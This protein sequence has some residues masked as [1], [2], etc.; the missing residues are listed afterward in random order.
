MVNG[1]AIGPEINTNGLSPDDISDLS[2]YNSALFGGII[3]QNGGLTTVRNSYNTGNITTFSSMSAGIM[4]NDWGATSYIINCYNTGDITASGNVGGLIGLGGYSI[5]NSYNTGV[6]TLFASSEG[7]NI[8]GLVG[9]RSRNAAVVSNSYNEGNI[10]VTSKVSKIYAAGLCGYC[11]SIDNS[12]NRGNITSKY[13]SSTLA[14]IYASSIGTGVTNVYN[15]GNITYENLAG[16]PGNQY[17]YAQASGI[18]TFS[19]SAARENAYNLGN[20]TIEVNSDFFKEIMVAGVNLTSNQPVNNCVNTGNITVNVN[21]PRTQTTSIFVSGISYMENVYNSFN[22][23]TLTIND[24]AL[25][26]PLSSD[27]YNHKLDIGEIAQRYGGHQTYNNKF[28]SNPDG[29]AVGSYPRDN[30]LS[31]SLEVGTYT[32]EATPSI[33]SIINGDNAFEIKSGETLPTLKVFNQ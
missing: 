27:G 17:T 18:G 2:N 24:S 31:E 6:L 14:G 10:V 3:G 13:A 8:G 12:Y 15:S 25:D 32:D 9:N 28:N 23:G 21:E 26:T 30:V 5:T 29:H 1:V 11:Q 33:L 19:G 16:S 7:N 4:G 22:A 20:I